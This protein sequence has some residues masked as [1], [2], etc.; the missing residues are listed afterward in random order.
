MG[1]CEHAQTCAHTHTQCN[2]NLKSKE[3]GKVPGKP[4]KSSLFLPSCLQ[5]L[6]SLEVSHRN[7]NFTSLRSVLETRAPLPQSKIYILDFL[8]ETIFLSGIWS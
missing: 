4:Q 6:L 3:E 8:L 5:L 2:N 1:A 7:H